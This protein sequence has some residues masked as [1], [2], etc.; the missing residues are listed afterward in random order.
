MLVN[1]E[2]FA[3]VP[4]SRIAAFLLSLQV[5]IVVVLFGA[6][7][8]GSTS[9]TP[10]TGGATTTATT[11]RTGTSTAS[12]ATATATAGASP[13]PSASVV[14]SSLTL[15]S[16]AFADGGAIPVEYTCSGQ[17]LSP[18]LHWT[19]TPAGTAA[20]ALIMDDPD[21]PLPGGFVHWVVF[22]LSPETTDL[23]A[24]A[25]LPPQAVPGK[26]GRGTQE[27]TGP[28]PPAGPAHHYRFALYA[29]DTPLNLTAGSSK[30]DVIAATAGQVL[31][32]AL[33]VGTFQR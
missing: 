1:P 11:S 7:S 5:A 21:A 27:Y 33:L 9:P 14:A 12:S 20:F 29:L 18:P 31:G 17:G 10:T 30:D 28:C 25:T 6:C 15:T 22:N 24:G 32:E 3:I 26:N 23:S 19:G 2:R 13:S 4:R 16:S 8:S